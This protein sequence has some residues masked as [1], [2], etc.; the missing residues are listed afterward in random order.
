MGTGVALPLALQVVY[1]VC[2]P[3]AARE[4]EGAVTS[5]GFAY[6]IAAA[7]VSVTASS[8]SLVTAV[9]L[10]RAGLDPARTTRHIVS[11]SWIALVV[12]GAAAGVFG[13]AG[14]RIAVALLGSTYGSGVG[15]EL[16]HLVLLFSLWGVASIGVAVAFPLIFV[17][18]LGRTLPWIAGAVVLAH[19]PVAFGAGRLLGLSGLALSMAVTT[20]VVLAVLLSELHVLR[21][22]LS[23]LLRAT[24]LVLVLAGLA[25]VLPAL[26]LPASFAA[27]AGVLLYAALIALVR[28]AGLRE[29]WFYLRALR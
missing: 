18:G 3:F 24:I 17:V 15:E 21:M 7:V 9:P 23:G 25:F 16:G 10:T 13:I 5:F 11:S 4:G 28:P 19:I 27:L 1:V 2:L 20:A 6:L 29:A 26:L 22:T 12:I 14:E 8:L